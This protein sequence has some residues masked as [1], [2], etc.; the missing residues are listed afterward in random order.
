MILCIVP[1]QRDL[2]QVGAIEYRVC[3]HP[4]LRVF[5]GLRVIEP[6]LACLY[7]LPAIHL[8]CGFCSRLQNMVFQM[9]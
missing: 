5:H 6:L 1:A 7:S 8:S 2:P 4:K 3:A 9:H